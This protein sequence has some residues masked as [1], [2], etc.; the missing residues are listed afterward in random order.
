MIK[1]RR[2]KQESVIVNPDNTTIGL[3][4]LMESLL[5]TLIKNDNEIYRLCYTTKGED[6]S[7]FGYYH[8]NSRAILDLSKIVKTL[9]IKRV[10]DLG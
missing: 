9:K 7:E 6:R 5:R 3:M 10:V 4:N 2:K 1:T 8:S